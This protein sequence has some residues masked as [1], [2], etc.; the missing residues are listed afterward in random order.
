MTAVDSSVVG[1]LILRPSCKLR[2]VNNLLLR[3]P[4]ACLH[5]IDGHHVPARPTARCEK[6]AS[7]ARGP[8][9]RLGRD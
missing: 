1:G 9:A 6:R 2:G 3:A 5:F 7:C 4:R 8:G